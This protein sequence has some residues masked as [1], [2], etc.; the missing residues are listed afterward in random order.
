M[1]TFYLKTTLRNAFYLKFIRNEIAE[2]MSDSHKKLPPCAYTYNMLFNN[3]IRSVTVC[4][5]PL[6]QN[7]GLEFRAYT[8]AAELHK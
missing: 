1:S 2:K 3:G 6:L 7:D 4:K 8:A 5:A